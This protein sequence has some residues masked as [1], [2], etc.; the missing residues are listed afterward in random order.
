M[1]SVYEKYTSLGRQDYTDQSTDGDLLVRLSLQ[2]KRWFS[3][4]FSEKRLF[5]SGNPPYSGLPPGV[6][7]TVSVG[8]RY[9]HLEDLRLHWTRER[10]KVSKHIHS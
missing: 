10:I 7:R 5:F 4:L 6:G 2:L 8:Y 1:E 9:K 3:I